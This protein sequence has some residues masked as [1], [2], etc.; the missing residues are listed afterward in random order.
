MRRIKKIQ[1]IAIAAT[2]AFSATAAMAA[3]TPYDLIRPTWPLSWD[4]TAFSK[5]DTTGTGMIDALNIDKTPASF[6]AGALMPDTLD[7][8]YFDAINS[9]ISPIRVNQAGYLESDKERLFYY[10]GS[11]KEFEV[12]DADGKSLKTKVTGFLSNTLVTTQSDWTIVGSRDAVSYRYK[13]AF[14]GPSGYIFVGKIP[15]NVPTNTRL[16]IKVGDEV[17]STFIVSDDVYTMTKDAALKFFGIQRSGNSESWFHGPSHLKDGAGKVVLG[18][19]AA[20]GYTS[21]EGA[22]QGGW[23]DCGD[24]LKESQTQAFAFAAL[25]LMS[26]TNPA[27]DVDHYAYNQ[28]E[29]VTTDG[30]P[31][32]LREAKH[33]ADFFLRAYEFAKGVID[34]MPVSVGNTGNDHVSW[35]RPEAQDY[36]P[37]ERGGSAGRDV[38]LGELGANVSAEIAAGLAIL[39]KNYKTY[40]KAFADSC[41]TVAEKLYDFAKSLAQGETYKNNKA[42]FTSST[43]INNNRV[44]DKLALASVALLYATSKKDYADDMIRA[45]DLFKLQQ[46]NDIGGAGYFAGGWFTG[47]SGS[48]LKGGTS[49]NFA[50]MHTYALY[51]LYKLILADKTKA[52][53]EYGL[54]EE[55]HLAAIEDCLASMIDNLADEATSG[56]G[57]I[58][59]PTTARNT[60]PL[61]YD[62]TWYSLYSIGSLY[63]FDQAGN[64]FDVL[65]YAEVAADIE[66]QG[67]TLPNIEGS[68]FKASEMRQLG[69][70]QLNYLF[71]VNPWDVSF[72]F[73][74]GDKNDAHPHHRAANP[75]GKSMPGLNYKYVCPV[76]GLL[77]GPTPSEQN[78]WNNSWSNFIIE[79]T[80]LEGSTLLLSA[81]TLVSNGGSD[82]YEKKCDN[83]KSGETSPFSG[84]T[85]ATACTYSEN[86]LG[87]FN[88]N[89]HNESLENIDSVVAY[90]YFEATEEDISSG[91]KPFILNCELYGLDGLMQLCPEDIK[92]MIK[93]EPKKVED[94]Y[95]KDNKTYTWEQQINLGTLGLG[96][97]K[98]LILYFTADSGSTS[99]IKL[100]DAWSFTAHSTTKDA[101]VYAGAPNWPMYQDRYQ[102][103]PQDPYI[104]IRSK[105]KLLWGYG[106]GETTSDRV[107]FVKPAVIA[108]ARMQVSNNKLYVLAN[109]QGTKTVKIF[110]LLGNQLTVKTFDGTRAE[111]N[112]AKLPQRGALIARVVQNGKVL[113]TQSIRIK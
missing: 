73:G 105:G 82:Y 106:P 113:A 75:E 77:G 59:L 79:E 78:S 102:D 56:N 110:D 85:Y 30:I 60:Y 74:V 51:A 84:E 4:S 37:A 86:T 10:I 90:V 99:E 103:P 87:M 54:T 3:T 26:A 23:Y 36:M 101:P 57:L 65:A 111:V 35:N 88:I 41:L 14:T 5:F 67:I 44:Y 89:F 21:K 24:H 45:K 112:L 2:F 108:K 100:A 38:R 40:D 80:C 72:V 29:F 104:V 19:D 16:R 107:G 46:V 97:L 93:S 49:T 92:D 47:F 63:N 6:K 17:S 50:D 81:L 20:E 68:E 58:T 13:V 1:P 98:K 109:A 48:M 22:L 11:A 28:G 53:T 70:N 91:A 39:A 94:T 12:V 64:I 31:D 7:Q 71:G 42:T 52:T 62:S 96:T 69:I 27:K 34:D 8:A 9:K 83:C 55:E 18:K 32:V 25:A 15:Q 61:H 95:N 76:G 43:Y 33:G 66:K